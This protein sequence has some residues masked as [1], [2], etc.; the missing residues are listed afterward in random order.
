MVVATAL[1][2]TGATISGISERVV[3]ELE[4]AQTEQWETIVGVHGQEDV[5]LYEI[6]MMLPI[7]DR[8]QTFSRGIQNMKVIPLS[9]ATGN[10]DVLLG[11]DLLHGFHLTLHGDLFILSN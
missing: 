8:Q 5:P 6:D 2:D 1:L 7:S 4:L 10:F 3:G 11:M 9:V